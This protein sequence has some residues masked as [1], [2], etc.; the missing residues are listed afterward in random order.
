MSRSTEDYLQNNKHKDYVDKVMISFKFKLM[1]AQ[2]NRL[3]LS[4]KRQRMNGEEV[5]E[6]ATI[7]QPT[8]MQGENERSQ[9][10]AM[11]KTSNLLRV[12]R[13]RQYADSMLLDALTACGV[14]KEFLIK[15]RLD[16]LDVAFKEKEL[17]MVDKT[18]NKLDSFAGIVPDKITTTETGSGIDYDALNNIPTQIPENAEIVEPKQLE[19]VNGTDIVEQPTELQTNAQGTTE[20]EVKES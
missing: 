9:K 7:L 11:R 1:I 18:L 2:Y 16:L 15:K 20:N 19:G 12:E 13:V 3:R 6:L 5:K 14:T 4:S 10:I 17:E 8:V